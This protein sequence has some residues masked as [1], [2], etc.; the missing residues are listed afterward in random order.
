MTATAA[1]TTSA[2]VSWT[3]PASGGPVTSYK[4]TPYIGSTA[5]TPTTITGTP[6]ATA[7]P[8]TG[9]TTG[10]TYTFTVQA[11]Q[12]QRRRPGVGA[13]QRRDAARR[14]VAPSAPTAVTRRARDAVGA[15]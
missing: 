13:V 7:R 6:P 5:Q 2:D 4:I 8:I 3:A 9:L 11:A 15:A 14:A 1:G 12:R 10:T